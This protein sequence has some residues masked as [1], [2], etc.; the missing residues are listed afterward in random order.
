MTPTLTRITY[1]STPAHGTSDIDVRRVL[2]TS[3][4]NNRRR[5]ITGALAFTGLRFLQVLEG[6]ADDVDPVLARIGQDPRHSDIQVL[7]RQ[8]VSTRLFDGWS[9]AY[10]VSHTFEC[11]LDD[12]Q[13]GRAD[14]AAL[15]EQVREAMDIGFPRAA[16][17]LAPG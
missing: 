7:A 8:A 14:R 12:A 5:D 17:G 2:A 9:M 6:L 10:L 15:P 13:A 3:Q 1:V 16:A 11:L 4:I